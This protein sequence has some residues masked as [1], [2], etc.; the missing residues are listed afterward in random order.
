ML[1][2][3]AMVNMYLCVVV[4]IF[5]LMPPAVDKRPTLSAMGLQL[6][7]PQKKKKK[8]KFSL[9]RLMAVFNK[10]ICKGALRQR[11]TKDL[12]IA[13]V[14]LTPDEFMLIKEI[15]IVIILFMTYPLIQPD[16]IIFWML[17]GFAGGY[18]I[19]EFWLKG[20]IKTIKATI[21][22]E[23]PDAIDLLGLCVNA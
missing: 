3:L 5:G 18:M 23:L 7:D 19:P 17:M 21:V 10:P 22:K 13:H 4:F 6:E 1:L 14:N 15:A 12:Q 20:R 9:L 16:M 11:L 8:K 2:T